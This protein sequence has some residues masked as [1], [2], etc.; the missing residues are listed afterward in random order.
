MLLSEITKQAAADLRANKL[1]ST[2]TLFGIIWGIM[3]IMILLGWG[4]GFRQMM[5]EGMSQL[6]ED[7]IFFNGGH[8]STG[9]G[10]H[11]AGRPVHV[12]L[13]DIEAI[14][15]LCPSV[16]K[17]NPQIAR[18]FHVKYGTE[19]RSYNMRGVLPQAK[20]MNNWFVAQG[21][22][23]NQDDI[24][25]RRRFAFIGNNIKEQLFGVDSNPVGETVRINGITFQIIGVAVHKK[26]Q[27]STINSRHDDQVLVP[28]TTAQ[29]LWG[30]GKRL[31]IIFAKPKDGKSS[32][33]AAEEIRNVMA[34]RH[35]YDPKD[36][37]ALFLI[38]FAFYE[39][40]LS[41][42]T[43]GLNVLLGL[44]GIVTLFIGGIGV[45]NIMFLSVQE[46]TNEIGIRKSLGAKKRDIRLQ[47]L[48]ES[49]FITSIG[50]FA[51]FI[52]GSAFL[53]AINLLPLPDTL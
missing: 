25:N 39:K 35:H 22:F 40:M 41:V 47:F 2:L 16:D 52:L 3:A 46:R 5:Y 21:R 18:W 45:M 9:I 4:F 13:D 42:L 28:L 53:G 23:I 36:E 10:G 44:I 49:L 27:S 24:K 30:D 38:E 48:A 15:Q 11:K 34:T 29:Q 8:T 51:G 37:E 20:Q 12:T 6:G 31:D 43:I 17:V 33:V 14:E 19:S 26:M 32:S 1:R 50:G 7:L